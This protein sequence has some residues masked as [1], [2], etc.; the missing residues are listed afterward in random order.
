MRLDVTGAVGLLALA[1]SACVADPASATRAALEPASPRSPR[2]VLDARASGER[3]EGRRLPPPLRS[4]ALPH[5]ELSSAGLE[6]LVVLDARFVEGGVVVVTPE[7]VLRFLPTR[8]APVD[9]DHGV[10]PPIAAAHDVLAYA[11]GLPPD[12]DIAR[13][14]LAAGTATQLTHGLAPAYS[15]ALSPDGSELLFV[16]SALGEPRLY[17]LDAHGHAEALAATA[18]TPSGPTA[19]QWDGA[20]LRF[21]DEHGTVALAPRT[22]A[23]VA[24]LRGAHGLAAL[25]R[26]ADLTRGV[27]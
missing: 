2:V 17:A 10:W 1:L 24:E 7:Q 14:G 20:T 23:V 8:S 6:G 22:G 12:L 3:L 11:R 27:R 26:I 16:S 5:Y 18:R 4:D 25:T 9:L 13:S 19:P 21:E 15:P